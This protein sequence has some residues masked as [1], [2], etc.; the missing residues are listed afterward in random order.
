M[1]IA[2]QEYEVRQHLVPHSSSVWSHEETTVAEHAFHWC[3]GS[4]CAED[5]LEE[6]MQDG[7]LRLMLHSFPRVSVM[8]KSVQSPKQG[9]ETFFQR[10]RPRTWHPRP[11]GQGLNSR[12]Q[13]HGHYRLASRHLEAKATSSRTPT[14]LLATFKWN[15]CICNHVCS[16]QN[17]AMQ[18]QQCWK[19]LPQ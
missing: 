16:M 9:L 19:L 18:T 14:L 13:G 1:L 12:G 4:R 8:T 7:E 2:V 3:W 15:S 17:C 6:A 11:Q 5:P 10:P